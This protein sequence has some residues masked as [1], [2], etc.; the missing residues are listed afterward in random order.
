MI[1]YREPKYGNSILYTASQQQCLEQLGIPLYQLKQAPIKAQQGT[2]ASEK[3][4]LIN[5]GQD[6]EFWTDLL[7]L[8]P[9]AKIR[10]QGVQ[11]TEVLT[12]SFYQQGEI[13]FHPNHLSTPIWQ[14]LT[15]SDKKAIWQW[16]H[17]QG[18]DD[19]NTPA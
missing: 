6:S 17:Q 19:A 13:E 12:W 2:E 15:W 7:V 9:Q 14:T 18:Q 10:T 16:L 5:P 11:L 3:G 1:F 4:E 8:F